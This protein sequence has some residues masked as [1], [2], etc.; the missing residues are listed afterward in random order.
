M[1]KPG[2]LKQMMEPQPHTG[3]GW[4]LGQTL[5][6]R[7]E[8]GGYVVGHS[9]GTGPAWGAMVRINPAT[10]NGFVLTVSGAQGA[11]NLLPHD[12]LYWETGVVTSTARLQV[13]QNRLRH[14]LL[15]MGIGSGVILLWRLKR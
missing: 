10:G 11:A 12:W 1:L 3:D 8:A 15:A 14:A 13:V 7:N 2:T 9:G 5:Y 4:G 6:A